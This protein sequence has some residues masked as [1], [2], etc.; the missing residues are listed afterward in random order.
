LPQP[1]Y[2]GSVPTQQAIVPTAP[3]TAQIA[4]ELNNPATTEYQEPPSPVSSS[5]VVGAATP[6]STPA[7]AAPPQASFFGFDQ[8]T[9]LII[10]VVI[11]FLVFMVATWE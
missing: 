10:L 11:A 2:P 3:S 7:L 1:I 4:A 6:V 5:L 8:N 9:I